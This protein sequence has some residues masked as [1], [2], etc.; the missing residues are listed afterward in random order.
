MAVAVAGRRGCTQQLTED[1]NKLKAS[2]QALERLRTH[3]EDANHRLQRYSRSSW[4]SR[5][6]GHQADKDAFI[7]LNTDIDR[8]ECGH[9]ARDRGRGL[10]ASTL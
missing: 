7:E 8:R 5:G 3:L 4:A 9:S 1:Q 6:C 2:Q 10:V